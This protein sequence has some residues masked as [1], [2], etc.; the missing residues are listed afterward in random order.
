M[1]SKMTLNQKDKLIDSQITKKE[2]PLH[3]ILNVIK[4]LLSEESR[5]INGEVITVG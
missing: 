4:F 5:F 3:E 1:T 2:V